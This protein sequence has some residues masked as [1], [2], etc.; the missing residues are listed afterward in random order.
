MSD[1][2]RRVAERILL[3]PELDAMLADTPGKI[4]EI[5]ALGCRFQHAPRL[6]IGTAMPLRF[7][8]EGEAIELRSKIV[9]S[10][11]KFSG[12]EK[13]YHSGLQFAEGV[14]AELAKLQTAL[15]KH[16]TRVLRRKFPELPLVMK[17]KPSAGAVPFMST[18]F[19]SRPAPPDIEPASASGYLEFR[20]R[21][22]RW[23]MKENTVLSQPRDGLS[24]PASL[25]PDAIESWKRCFE[26]AEEPVRRMIRAALELR[27]S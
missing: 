13:Y 6:A 15:G 5:A 18:P 3:Q 20:W 10:E 4:G 17:P 21:E 19:L 22:G 14:A 16:L 7:T 2:Q 12:G 27:V 9:W 11:L 26:G 25:E 23:E 24:F 1:E 8:W